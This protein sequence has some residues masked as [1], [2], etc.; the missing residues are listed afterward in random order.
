MLIR[1]EFFKEEYGTTYLIKSLMTINENYKMEFLCQ[2]IT[3]GEKLSESLARISFLMANLFYR[4]IE[5][6]STVAYP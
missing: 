1:S 2:K 5:I 6:E 4:R 3:W